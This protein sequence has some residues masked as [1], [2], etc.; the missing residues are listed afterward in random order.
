MDY[1]VFL[2]TLSHTSFVDELISSKT[3]SDWIAASY[4]HPSDFHIIEDESMQSLSTQLSFW[5][6]AFRGAHRIS[7]LEDDVERKKFML[8]KNP[9]F[10]MRNHFTQIVIEEA[11]AGN[12]SGIDR[13]LAV[14]LDPFSEGTEQQSK[15]FAGKV[16]N[17][18]RE[19]KC[20]C[21]S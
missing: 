3:L 5:Y 14:L 6:T 16:P 21:S 9:K 8:S 1:T 19:Y 18:S 15:E 7:G 4:K 12:P 10:T 11:E 17:F 20:S 13:Y 2:R